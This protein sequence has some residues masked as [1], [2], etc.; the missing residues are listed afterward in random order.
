MASV[1]TL[2]IR[3]TA[4]RAAVAAAVSAATPSPEPSASASPPVFGYTD[5]GIPGA[6][7]G[8][9]T[10]LS[11]TAVV[12]GRI[13]SDTE[14]LAATLARP[15]VTSI[16]MA[17]A[18]RSLAADAALGRDLTAR[19]MGWIA[20]RGAVSQLDGFYL[21]IADTARTGLRFSLADK[22]SYRAT[23]ETMLAVLAD[24]ASVDAGARDFAATVHLE[25]APVETVGP[26]ASPVPPTPAPPTAPPPIA[27]P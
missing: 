22:E 27:N 19:M 2:S 17:R 6:P 4:D 1:I 12:N 24:L 23:G 13:A 18:L 15:E 8:A 9:S 26:G 7:A 16:E 14:T 10:A 3:D 20:A 21:A 25:M 5:V 11:G